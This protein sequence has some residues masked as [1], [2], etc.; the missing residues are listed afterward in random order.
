M[1]STNISA[2][3]AS[4]SANPASAVPT[5]SYDQTVAENACRITD[6]LILQ[7]HCNARDLNVP[8]DE[9]ILPLPPN[10]N[11]P[12]NKLHHWVTA[13]A[14]LSLASQA[15]GLALLNSIMPTQAS[16]S[17]CP[18]V[19]A[20]A[21]VL[22]DSSKEAI[23]SGTINSTYNFSIHSFIQDLTDAGQYCP[24][25]LFSAENTEHLHQEGHSLKCTKIHIGRVSHH[26]LDLSQF[27]SEL[28]LDTL[29][30]QEAYQWY[31]TWIMDVGDTV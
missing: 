25:I 24:L 8:A 28:S 10:P 19:S 11:V 31:I 29:T 17:S 6:N 23:S 7:N 30:W 12:A 9:P 5:L 4:S 26:L 18:N 2:S 13:F 15:Q 16:T 20:V 27:E 21:K 14:Q 22:F 1:S 3:T